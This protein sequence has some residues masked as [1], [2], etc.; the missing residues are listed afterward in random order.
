MYINNFV[1]FFFHNG[2]QGVL[3]RYHILLWT[4]ARCP[5]LQIERS[6]LLPRLGFRV[7][8]A[9]MSLVFGSPCGFFSWWRRRKNSRPLTKFWTLEH[10]SFAWPT[11]ICFIEV[12]WI[13]NVV[14]PI[15]IHI[16]NIGKMMKLFSP[17]KDGCYLCM[18]RALSLHK[19]THQHL[20]LTVSLASLIPM[21]SYCS[22]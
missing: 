20:H 16:Y 7:C 2:W 18:W 3:Y 15:C 6:P 4:M 5:P 9:S 22:I 17:F 21:H 1:K 19:H 13:I 14:Y 8:F 12:L 11:L 10:G